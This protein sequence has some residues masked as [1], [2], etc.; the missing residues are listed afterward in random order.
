MIVP[1]ITCVWG[2]EIIEHVLHPADGT[3]TPAEQQTQAS[4]RYGRRVRKPARFLLVADQ[5]EE[6]EVVEIGPSRDRSEVVEI[7]PSRDRS[8]VVE[9][10]PS[11]DRSEVV[12]MGASQVRSEDT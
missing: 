12:E 11:R 6:G 8:E 10:G 3:P 9:I 7:G 4:T 2:F 5:N 1:R